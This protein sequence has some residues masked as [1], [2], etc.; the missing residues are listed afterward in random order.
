MSYSKHNLYWGAYEEEDGDYIGLNNSHWVVRKHL[1]DGAFTDST[2][3]HGEICLIL[4][5]ENISFW[6]VM[7][8]ISK[9]EAKELIKT[10][11]CYV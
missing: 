3:A 6:P 7:S 10:L 11:K 8:F 9:D 2:I 4:E 1:G 5:D